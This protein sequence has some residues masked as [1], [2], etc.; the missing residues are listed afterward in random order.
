MRGCY[1]YITDWMNVFPFSFVLSFTFFIFYF[2]KMDEC[3]SS[4]WKTGLPAKFWIFVL[5]F[6][7]LVMLSFPKWLLLF[8]NKSSWRKENDLSWCARSH[9]GKSRGES[10]KL[11]SRL[12][13]LIVWPDYFP[14]QT[15]LA[16]FRWSGWRKQCCHIWRTNEQVPSILS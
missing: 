14:K 13:V 6:F 1:K 9:F 8:I 2:S 11:Q 12:F 10:G 15:Y 4:G 7:L 5:F 3:V 16:D